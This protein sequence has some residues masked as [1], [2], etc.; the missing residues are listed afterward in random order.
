MQSMLS[1]MGHVYLGWVVLIFVSVVQSTPS[2]LPG[3]SGNEGEQ[4]ENK[5]AGKGLW[6]SIG[7]SIKTP[8]EAM[9][10][11]VD[12][13]HDHDEYDDLYN[14]Q[15]LG[16]ISQ[17]KNLMSSMVE[18]RRDDA[19]GQEDETIMVRPPWRRPHHFWLMRQEKKR[20]EAGK[21][22]W[23]TMNFCYYPLFKQ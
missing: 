22:T 14:D 7:E 18:R 20:R 6:N 1:V 8:G 19:L 11:Q 12:L 23:C 10:T 16:N 9:P 4:Q 13:P 5:D 15:E 17:K 2:G 21:A 3:K